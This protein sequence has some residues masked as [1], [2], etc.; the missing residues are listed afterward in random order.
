MDGIHD[1][2]GRQ[3]FGAVPRGPEAE[4]TFSADWQ[5]RVFG[6]SAVGGLANTDAFRHAVERVEPSR[7]LSVG[8]WGRW[9]T[10]LESLARENDPRV[11][12]TGAGGSPVRPIQRAPLFRPGDRVRVRDLHTS[13]HTRLPG[14]VRG[15]CGVIAIQQGG[16]IY[17]DSHAHGEGEQPQYA[18]AVRFEGHELWGDTAEPATRV[19][20]DLFEPYLEALAQ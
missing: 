6:L 5:R 3:G 18:Y 7:Y 14:Y 13:G 15:R 2:G 17:P 4:Q 16:W 10:A 20:V 9:L 12:P 1:L 19:Y 11:A 8:Y